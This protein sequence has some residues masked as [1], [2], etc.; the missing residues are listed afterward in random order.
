MKG[1]PVTVENIK[2]SVK[3]EYERVKNNFNRYS[4]SESFKR[5][6]DTANEIFTTLG[7]VFLVMIKVVLVIIFIIALIVFLL[8]IIGVMANGWNFH[9]W[10]LSA[11]PFREHIGLV[12]HDI[13]F[14]SIALMFVIL[15]PVVSILAGI[16]KLVFNI[17]TRY[18]ILSAFAWTIWSLA[19]V[20]VIISLISGKNLVSN[21]YKEKDE[22]LLEL[23]DSKPLYINV[24]DSSLSGWKIEYYSFF[25][26]DIIHNK[27]NDVCYLEPRLY[28]RT[29]NDNSTRLVIEKTSTIPPFWDDNYQDFQYEWYQQDT[30]LVFDNYF[31]INEDDIWQLP[32]MNIFLYVPD[33]QKL[34][35]DKS[36]KDLMENKDEEDYLTVDYNTRLIMENGRLKALNP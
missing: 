21:T 34:F 24:D 27:I 33:G 2:E 26:R 29:S 10:P 7:Q 15:I 9:T 19:L 31:K 25:G 14:F 12:F 8:V 18:G 4:Q 32:G 23:N 16:I 35:I 36:L 6:R 28:I 5:T 30:M 22:S 13:S 3:S 1:R 20:F 11:I 17:R